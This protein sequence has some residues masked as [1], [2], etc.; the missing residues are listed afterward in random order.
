MKK[1][2][3]I[4]FIVI[5]NIFGFEDNKIDAQYSYNIEVGERTDN[6]VWNIGNVDYVTG[7]NTYHPNILSELSWKDI[8]SYYGKLELY[9][10]DGDY[11]LKLNYLKS[12]DSNSGS[13]QDSDYY[14]NNRTGEFS[15]SNNKA[16][17][18]Y[19]EDYSIW[20]GENYNFS[21]SSNFI[22]WLGYEVNKQ[23]L[24][25]N[26]GTQTIG[27]PIS[28]LGLNSTYDTK[29]TGYFTGLEYSYSMSS[30]RFNTNIMY[31]KLSYEAYAN[32]N[33]RSDLEHPI[34]F[35]HSSKNGYG[36]GYE[37]KLSY[38]FNNTITIFSNYTKKIFS[39]KN[40]QAMN[41]NSDGSIGFAYLNNVKLETNMI[42]IGIHYKF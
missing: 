41:Y 1:I 30:F 24:K 34:S 6:I 33:L 3:F 39:V 40:G 22:F 4:C 36:I 21:K 5:S 20:L 16:N 15:R 2:I 28:L 32:W 11:R 35:K 10:E 8:K 18:S 14:Y 29:W 31:H 19:F 42:S 9:G 25:I 13:N 38:I 37:I 17:D 12:L 7:G 26:N 27:G 23:F